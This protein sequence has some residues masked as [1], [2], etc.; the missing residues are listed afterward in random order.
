MEDLKEERKIAEDALEK[1]HREN[2]EMRFKFL[3]SLEKMV[4]IMEKN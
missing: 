1:R 4:S 3:A 2:M